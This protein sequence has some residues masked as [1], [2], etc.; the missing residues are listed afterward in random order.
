ME[1]R[2]YPGLETND[3][4]RQVC[5]NMRCSAIKRI[6]RGLSGGYWKH[7]YAGDL[8]SKRIYTRWTANEVDKALWRSL[9]GEDS[10]LNSE[11]AYEIASF[12]YDSIM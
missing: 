5:L 8:A 12:A 11:D 9:F 4:S 6:G 10:E 3:S 1:Q 2:L 7:Q